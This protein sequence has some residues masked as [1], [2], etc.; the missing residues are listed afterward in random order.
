MP[1]STRIYKK[2]NSFT[3]IRHH[4]AWKDIVPPIRSLK[5]RLSTL[6][7]SDYKK[8]IVRSAC[9]ELLGEEPIK[10]DVIPF[11]LFSHNLDEINQL[12]DVDLPRYLY[13]RFRYE[14]FPQRLRLDDFPPCLQI[15]PASVCNYRCLFCY[16]IDEEFTR[17]SNGMM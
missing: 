12:E 3:D 11:Q 16:Q 7:L 9:A 2:Q 6:S 5:D 15:E 4:K 1:P 13:Y 10:K 14:T 17:K 8:G